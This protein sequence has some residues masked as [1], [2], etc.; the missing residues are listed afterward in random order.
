MN[1]K[2]RPV[3]YALTALMVLW[4][5]GECRYRSGGADAIL[6]Q[7]GHA[8]DS[9]ASVTDRR[10]A[11]LAAREVE[12]ESTLARTG[13]ELAAARATVARLNAGRRPVETLPDSVPVLRQQLVLSDSII[14][15]DSVIFRQQD[16]VIVIWTARAEERGALLTRALAER[17]QFKAQRDAWQHRANRRFVCAGGPAI[18]GSLG[19]R[20]LAGVGVVC[21]FRL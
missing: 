11:E 9:S 7:E 20:A 3:L 6:R 8:T 15:A 14:R 10:V 13:R 2:L 1:D 5:W 19:G 18:V 17:D 12:R 4:A 16:S 21:G